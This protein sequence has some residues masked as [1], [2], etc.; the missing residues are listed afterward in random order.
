MLVRNSII[1]RIVKDNLCLGCGLCE[2]VC[3]KESAEM[4]IS[5]NGFFLPNLKILNKKG[6]QIIKRICPGIN[7]VN[8]IPFSKS[9]RIWGR[10]EK[11][12]SGYSADN[13]IRS[14]GSS[15]GIISSLAV[16]LLEHKVV[17]AILQVGGDT[18]EY[19]HNHLRISRNKADVLECASS[20]YAPALV[21]NSLLETLNNSTDLFCFVGKPCDISALKNI[22]I[23]YPQYKG[24]FKL[25][26]AIMCAGMPSFIGTQRIIEA[27]QAF[28]PVKNLVYRGNGWPGNFSFDDRNGKSFK[29]S[30]NDS[31]GKVLGK[32]VHFRCKI[33]P[34]GIGLQADI[35]IGDAWET[36]NG[37]PDFTEKEGRSLIIARTLVGQTCLANAEKDHS[38][39]LR[40]LDFGQL[41]LIQPYQ[42]N[43][44]QRVGVR[45]LAFSMACQRI[46]NFKNM[47]LF[48]NTAKANPFVLAK[49][50][51]GTLKRS[52]KN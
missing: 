47:E 27:F 30:Y 44:R 51:I 5:E 35:A 24:R 43:R 8:D 45:I 39:V 40:P 3:G 7:V 15:G 2:S 10:I 9:E 6:E 33:C 21:F 46:L 18:N 26:I 29:M 25:T 13:E 23:E 52:V 4:K 11:L 19:R 16:Y 31:W 1:S 34:D 20:R 36:K 48:C 38:I 42:Y 17:D 50:F 32:F 49:E 41:Q 14:K 37:Y 28:Q 12:H 22:L